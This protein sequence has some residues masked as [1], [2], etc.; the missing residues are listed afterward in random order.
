MRPVRELPGPDSDD[1]CD[2]DIMVRDRDAQEIMPLELDAL[3]EVWVDSLRP[4]WKEA[5]IVSV[6]ERSGIVVGKRP[7]SAERWDTITIP[8][9][10]VKKRIRLPPTTNPMTPQQPVS[11]TRSI[12]CI[13]ASGEKRSLGVIGCPCCDE[14]FDQP[15]DLAKH[16]II[17]HEPDHPPTKSMVSMISE[18]GDPFEALRLLGKTVASSGD[19][20]AFEDLGR[21]VQRKKFTRLSKYQRGRPVNALAYFVQG[22]AHSN[23]SPFI[24]PREAG[25]IPQP[26]NGLTELSSHYDDPEQSTLIACLD[27][28]RGSENVTNVTNEGFPAAPSIACSSVFIHNSHEFFTSIN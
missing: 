13:G 1:E 12:G 19:T 24:I 3:V 7:G 2:D 5:I 25:H 9:S 8:Y 27:D 28:L 26:I 15:F 6:D 16:L 22:V 10:A 17:V 21:S 14:F 4:S 20:K 18:C 11:S 23:D